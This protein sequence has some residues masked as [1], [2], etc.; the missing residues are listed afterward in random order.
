MRPKFNPKWAI[1]GLMPMPAPQPRSVPE[2]Q[3][4]L[5]Y[6]LPIAQPGDTKPSQVV[7]IDT[8]PHMPTAADE[9]V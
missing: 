6:G 9:S 7:H 8:E 4:E 5:G 1:T 2:I 3:D